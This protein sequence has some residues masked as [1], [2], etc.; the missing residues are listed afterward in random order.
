MQF[1]KT[2]AAVPSEWQA[3]CNTVHF[4][5]SQRT[6]FN[7]ATAVIA[8]SQLRFQYQHVFVTRIA[9]YV[10]MEHRRFAELQ[11]KYR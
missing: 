9:K 3:I 6:V 5:I 2:G 4:I 11:K 10:V 1:P 8:Q 7:I